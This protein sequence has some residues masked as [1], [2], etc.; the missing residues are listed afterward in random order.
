MSSF[1]DRRRGFEAKFAHDNDLEFRAKVRRNRMLAIWAAKL[2]ER[3][4]EAYTKEI[5]AADLEMRSDK[6]VFAKLAADLEGKVGQVE[7]LQVMVDTH[8]KAKSQ[9]MAKG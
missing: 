9:V 6:P 7:I 4:P 2:I 5:L 8:C 1:D 3:D